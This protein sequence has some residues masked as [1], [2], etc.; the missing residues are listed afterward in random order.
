LKIEDQT[1]IVTK[2]WVEDVVIGLNLCP[3]ARPSWDRGDW[4]IDSLY[5]DDHIELIDQSIDKITRISEKMNETSV[6]NFLLVMPKCRDS[7]IPF[8]NL[9]SLIELELDRTKITDQVQMVIFHP[10][11]RFEGE[12]KNARG[13]YVNRSPFPMIHI[14][15]KS[16]M[17]AV[18]DRLGD[19][20]GEE[21]SLKNNDLLM[22]LGQEEFESK[23]LRY[24]AG[25]W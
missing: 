25:Y 8:L 24:I 2:K 21:V 10:E 12:S 6:E 19:H 7:F 20:I 14:L 22:A 17:D 18:V 16:A 23:V 5:S 9:C 11:F 13:N 4:E 3:F 1:Y 15:K